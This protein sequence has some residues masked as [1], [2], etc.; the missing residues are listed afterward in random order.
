MTAALFKGLEP[1]ALATNIADMWERWDAG[2]NKWKDR[3]AEVVQYVY[4]TSTQETTNKSNPW[5]HSTHIPKLTQIHDNLGANYA[6]ALFGGRQWFDFDPANEAAT[7]RELRNKVVAFLRTKHDLSDT[8]LELRKCLNDWVQTG[9]AFAQLHYVREEAPDILRASDEPV[10]SYE[11]PR[12][13][14]ISP[15]DI[16]FDFQARS[17]ADSPKIIRRLT[18]IGDLLSNFEDNNATLNWDETVVTN[19]VRMRSAVN[20][21]KPQQIN[22]NV[23]F[24]M[25]GFTDASSY[26]SSGQVELLDFYGDIFD[27]P[28]GKFLRRNKVTIVDRRWVLCKEEIKTRTGKPLIFHVG[29]RK[30]PDNLWAMGPLDNLVGMQYLVD[31]LE[32]ARADAFDKMITPD[33]V[34][35]GNVQVEERGP[36]TAYYLPDGNGSVSNLAPDATILQADLQIQIKEAQMEAYAGAPR[37]AMGMRTPGEKTK[38][39]VQQLQNAATRLF[40]HKIEDFE[41]EF[42]EPIL[43]GEL[44]I[45]V[46]YLDSTAEAR[47][48]DAETGLI[49]FVEITQ[50]D[51]QA[52]GK[53][54]ARGASHFRQK[55][56]LVQELGQFMSQLNQ[57]PSVAQHVP[58]EKLAELMVNT[59][60][61]DNYGLFS[62][63]VRITEQVEAN[64]RLQA[65]QSQ[66]AR[67]EAAAETVMTA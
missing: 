15:Y 7:D 67:D 26:F 27:H 30:R 18:N 48:D 33:R 35:V 58:A 47:V 29:W 38:F 60:G 56:V 39:E 42:I 49:Q 53:L 2:R 44:E 3:V 11:G 5:S 16:V 1:H 41:K 21:S 54:R 64:N 24:K 25:D 34:I 59:L 55:A 40:Q 31:H 14:R 12:V 28:S 20:G 19:I 9:N 37:E 4:A 51:L 10:V 61:F 57:D 52:S 22:K 17:F 43:N 65:A 50:D 23:Q 63:Y 8:V 36:V 32:N 45:T 66:M 6:D 46:R 13:E 62:P